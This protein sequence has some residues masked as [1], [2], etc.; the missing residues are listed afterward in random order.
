MIYRFAATPTVVS[1][2][3]SLWVQQLPL[4]F[5]DSTLS[6]AEAGYILLCAEPWLTTLVRLIL[7]IIDPGLRD[8]GV[9]STPMND[10]H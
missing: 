5:A 9:A 1:G 3:A 7:A 4:P 10:S 2:A 8:E 6:R